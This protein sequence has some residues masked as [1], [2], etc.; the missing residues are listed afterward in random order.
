[1]AGFS[2]PARFG[3]LTRNPDDDQSLPRDRTAN[4]GIPQGVPMLSVTELSMAA[5]ALRFQASVLDQVKLSPFPTTADMRS[6][7]EKFEQQ[8]NQRLANR[9]NADFDWWRRQ[10]AG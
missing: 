7:A 8:A 6:T 9:N 10:E 2:P 4:D 5:R 1:M 3:D